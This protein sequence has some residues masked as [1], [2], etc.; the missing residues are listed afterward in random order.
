MQ[1]P[2]HSPD[3]TP[4]IRPGE[5]GGTAQTVAFMSRHKEKRTDRAAL[6]WLVHRATAIRAA[7]IR[8]AATTA[9]RRAAWPRAPRGRRVRGRGGEG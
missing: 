7:Q 2:W 3:A 1:L 5:G 8:R 4:P 9:A 6:T